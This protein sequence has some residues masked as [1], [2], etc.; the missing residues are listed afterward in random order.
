[1][2]R[3]LFIQE[4]YLTIAGQTAPGD[5][6]LLKGTDASR[7]K[8]LV[9][10]DVHDVIIRYLRVRSGAHGDP[11][12][13]QINIS[14]DSGV[15]DVII[16][17]TSLSWSLDENLSIHRNIPAGAAPTSWPPIYNITVQRSLLAEGLYPHSTG[18]QVGGEADL[19][20]WQGVY[21]LS[22]HHNLLA[23]S[24]HRNPGLGSSGVQ[25]INNVIYNWGTKASETHRGSRVDVIGNYYKPGSLSDPRRL[26]VHN[27][28]PKGQPHRRYADP[29]LYVAGNVAPPYFTEAEA[30]NRAMFRIHYAETPLPEHFF[31]TTP[32]P[33]VPLPVT[34]TSAA[35]AYQAVLADVGANARLDCEGQWVA[36]GDAVDA[37]LVADVRQGRSQRPGVQTLTHASHEEQVGG[38]PPMQ[39]A[40]A[41][42]DTDH[43]GMPD[44]WE[45]ARGVL[46]PKVDDSAG[47]NLDL[48][49]TNIEVYLNGQGSAQIVG[50]F[51]ELCR[52]SK[53][54]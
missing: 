46:N 54:D 13:G 34:I 7:N 32:L 27:A 35:E 30:D 52:E 18:I 10:K 31:R 42:L 43:D 14:I 20:G 5:G 26:W 53:V 16:D 28:F 22:L 40:G 48:H 9:L 3:P 51:G 15:H 49:Y 50:V 11:G 8:M 24:S 6:I 41:C 23:H 1:L 47:N 4:P 39:A 29:S 38:Y 25:V 17:H 21:N 2:K 37:R 19:D 33:P 12:R 45:I 36:N 44:A